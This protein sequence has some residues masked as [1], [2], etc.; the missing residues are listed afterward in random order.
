MWFDG[1]TDDVMFMWWWRWRASSEDLSCF[2]VFHVSVMFWL[3][4]LLKDAS[5]LQLKEF[6]PWCLIFMRASILHVEAN[7]CS[8]SSSGW[9]L[10]LSSTS[11]SPPDGVEGQGQGRVLHTSDSS[12]APHAPAGLLLLSARSPLSQLT[13]CFQLSADLFSP[14]LAARPPSFLAVSYKIKTLFSFTGVKNVSFLYLWDQAD[15]PWFKHLTWLCSFCPSG[16]LTIIA[17]NKGK[18]TWKTHFY[19]D[20]KL[21]CTITRATVTMVILRATLYVDP[22][23]WIHF[24]MDHQNISLC[25]SCEDNQRSLKPTCSHIIAVL[26]CITAAE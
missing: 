16:T 14:L 2:F 1:C 19:H 9:F 5:S 11:E 23:V 10:N 20:A 25:R 26:I 6:L 13:S 4:M 22:H 12:S 17:D 8:A 24:Y 15:L 21:W 3:K 7:F 18:V